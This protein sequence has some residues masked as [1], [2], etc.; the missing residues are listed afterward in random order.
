M[1][2]ELLQVRT[3][4]VSY[5]TREG[6]IR[7]VEDVTFSVSRGERLGLV[8]E[9]GCGKTTTA[10][11]LLRLIEPPGRI[12]AGEVLLDGVDLLQL[13][14]EEMRKARFARISLVLQGAMN[15]L[16]PV[17]RVKHQFNDTVQAH[18]GHVP[19]A[20]QESRNEELLASVG[21]GPEVA[22]MYPHE[23]SGGMK[24]RVSIAMAIALGPELIVADEPTSALDVVVQR[25]VMQ[26]LRRVQTEIGAGLI[27]VG[28]DMGLM[29]QFVT[30]VAVMYAGKLVEI[31]SV[32]D[33]L[34][35]PLHPYTAALIAS[36]PSLGAKRVFKGLGG[37]T[38]SLL[39]PPP[40]CRFHPRCSRAMDQCSVH[41]PALID[42][43][44]DRRVACHLFGGPN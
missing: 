42:E 25:Q 33:V 10:Y 39:R 34:R 3:L 8:G 27:L 11:A 14:D 22:D 26:T 20:E 17:M 43:G 24:Q 1:T 40:G 7:A 12:E 13:P 41:E 18:N 4:R 36:L 15:S 31:G 28:H 21:L 5:Y 29:A 6:M 19:R 44:A 37:L 35:N 16:N 2:G 38:P 32:R 9:S 23:L 30:R